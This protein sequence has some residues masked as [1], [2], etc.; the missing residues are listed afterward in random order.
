V[1]QD[2]V[3]EPSMLPARNFRQEDH[4]DEIAAPVHRLTTKRP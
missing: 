2:D 3:P 4:A 1:K